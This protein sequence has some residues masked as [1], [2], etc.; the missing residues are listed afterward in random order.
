MCIKGVCTASPIAPVSICPF[1]DEVVQSGT[2]AITLATSF[3]TC[4]NFLSILVTNGK[5]E[6]EFC[7][8]DTGKSKC[9][10]SC[11]SLNQKLKS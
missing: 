10:L 5:S 6:A 4:Q 9:C 11:L 7:A 1:G 3:E 8:S 2:L